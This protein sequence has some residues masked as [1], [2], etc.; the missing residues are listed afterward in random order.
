MFRQL[1]SHIIP[2]MLKKLFAASIALVVTLGAYVLAQPPQQQQQQPPAA[3]QQPPPTPAPAQTTPTPPPALKFQ[4][5]PRFPRDAAEFDQ[6]FKKISNWGRWG[7]DDQL[8]TVN[9]ITEA[10]RRQAADLVKR[11]ITVSIAH[12][13][14]TDKAVDN[15][16][17]FSH[18]MGRGFTTDTY[19]VSY[20]GYAHS[21]M[22][23]LCH[24]LYQKQTYNGYS[25]A[26]VNTEKGCMKLGIHNLKNGIVTRGVLIDIARL[27]GLPYLEPGTPIFIE[28]IE[29]W[30]K[31]VG[32][33]VQ[34]GDVMLVRT[35]R[36]ARREKLGP[37][38]VG[39]NAAGLHASVATFLKDRG[40]AILGGDAAQDVTPSGVQS[41]GLPIHTLAITALG[42][43]LLDNQD[44]EALGDMAEK[45]K[46]WEFMLTIA[47]I[48]AV[49][50]TGFPVNALATF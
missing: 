12:N 50:G 10:K 31:K 8:G 22:D 24:I 47:P 16:Q 17:P 11:G 4:G 34:S 3:G 6:M 35:G 40:V 46:R 30:E 14:M 45:L 2:G 20:H 18:V 13:P 7:K 43:N 41:Q 39:G 44:L 21:H 38:N 42:M 37:W 33:K 48:P 23:A 25:T 26:D 32:I 9:L 36:W 49:G 1:E 29:A 28:D 27:K 15:P 19:S 5:E